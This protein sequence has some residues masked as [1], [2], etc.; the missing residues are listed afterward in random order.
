MLD[1]KIFAYQRLKGLTHLKKA[2]EMKNPHAFLLMAKIL[3]NGLFGEEKNMEQ[4]L[5]YFERAF[6]HKATQKEALKYLVDYEKEQQNY[7]K[8]VQEGRCV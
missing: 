7:E 4:A 5:I 3:Q 6:Y 2:V 1:G 8:A